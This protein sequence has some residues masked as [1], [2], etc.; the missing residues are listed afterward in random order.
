[1]SAHWVSKGELLGSPKGKH[2]GH[3][4]IPVVGNKVLKDHARTV[5][6]VDV[7]PVHPGMLGLHSRRKE[8]VPCPSQELTA[9]S[10]GL[11]AVAGLDILA[12]L[13][14]EI[15]LDHHGTAEGYIIPAL[16]D[17]VEL[18]RQD[19]VG[20]VR[21]IGHEEGKINEMMRVCQLG[22]Q[23]EVLAEIRRGVFQR[24]KDEDA[25]LVEDGLGGGLDRVEVDV[26]D[27]RGIDLQWSVVVVD[28]G[29]LEMGIPRLLLV[30]RHVHWWF[31]WS[32]AVE[33]SYAGC[34]PGA[35]TEH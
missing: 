12:E 19:G 26:L 2:T 14:V 11:K 29:R 28:H 10:L 5:H 20:V 8:V 17:A 16:L 25:L 32:P 34:Q 15:L 21:G 7:P 30:K 18:G 6:N 22:E 1:M 33:A 27:G 13:E 3:Q 35:L 24:G 4:D 23:F 31:G 9:R